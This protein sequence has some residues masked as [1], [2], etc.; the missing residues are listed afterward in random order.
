MKNKWG[1]YIFIGKEAW[2]RPPAVANKYILSPFI[3]RWPS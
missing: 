1:Q 3:G 2:G